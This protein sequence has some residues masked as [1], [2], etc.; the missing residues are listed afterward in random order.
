MFTKNFFASVFMICT[1]IFAS[2]GQCAPSPQF[3]ADKSMLAYAE[4]YAY[5]K[6]ENAKFAGISQNDIN[7]LHKFIAKF[8]LG[9]EFDEFCLSDESLAKISEAYI[10]KLKNSMNIQKKN[11]KK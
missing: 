10:A 1:I 4:V 7:E 3:G 2:I 8:E 11:Y 6:S 5:S 9:N